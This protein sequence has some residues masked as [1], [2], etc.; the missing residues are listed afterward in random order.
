LT[1]T[2]GSYVILKIMTTASDRYII[3]QPYSILAPRETNNMFVYLRPQRGKG[4]RERDMLPIGVD[5]IK[6][7]FGEVEDA[8]WARH[9]ISI[10][11]REQQ[12]RE[13]KRLFQAACLV[14]RVTERPGRVRT[15]TLGVK[16]LKP[17]TTVKPSRPLR[18]LRLPS[19]KT[20][21]GEDLNEWLAVNVC[22]FFDQIISIYGTV[23]S[24][25]TKE[26]CPR[27]TAGPNFECRWADGD[28][29]RTPIA[30]SAP[31]YIEFLFIWIQSQ[32][33]D[34]ALFP[35]KPGVP[36]P[37]HFRSIVRT[38]FKRMFRV[39][40]HIYH[41]HWREV[42]SLGIDTQLQTCSRHL[43]TFVKEFSLI[44]EREFVPLTRVI[45]P[46]WGRGRER[47]TV[48]REGE[49]QKRREAL[50][51]EGEREREREREEEEEDS[52]SCPGEI[53]RA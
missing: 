42:V 13:Y 19:V 49:T 43:I 40:V 15:L 32:I 2:C 51:T 44:D 9:A 34:E 24:V 47:V 12:Q 30:C 27:M 11:D 5:K 14:K 20:P 26:S 46:Y 7:C 45:T 16:R 41:S 38:I 35:Y 21:E 37:S 52:D 53:F 36:F 17:R 48:T 18:P 3:R 4:D 39:Y 23:E 10:G 6:L 8:N 28:K 29:Y 25:C 50:E 22:D 1:N 33:E 31:E